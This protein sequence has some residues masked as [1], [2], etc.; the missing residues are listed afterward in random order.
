[1][2]KIDN[3]LKNWQGF[4]DIARH[5]EL[6]DATVWALGLSAWFSGCI[7]AGGSVPRRGSL[8]LQNQ[9]MTSFQR[10]NRGWPNRLRRLGAPPQISHRQSIPRFYDEYHINQN[11][12]LALHHR[13]S[14]VSYCLASDDERSAIPGG[15]H[16]MKRLRAKCIKTLRNKKSIWL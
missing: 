16:N 1:M 5:Q 4:S 14:M 12:P 7:T 3:S 2:K 15:K 13:L 8:W 6:W 10:G 11:R 9:F